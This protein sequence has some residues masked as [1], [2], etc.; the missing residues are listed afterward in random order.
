[1][2]KIYLK[3][4]TVCLFCFVL[5]SS[6]AS[7]SGVSN[8]QPDD[9]FLADLDEFYL[10]DLNILS[11]YNKKKPSA[12][13]I[14]FYCNPRTNNVK[15]RFKIGMDYIGL[16]IPYSERVKIGN[17]FD[18]YTEAIKNPKLENIKISKKTAFQ[19]GEIGIGWGV[20]GISN[21]VDTTYLASYQF[22]ENNK[23]YFALKF[24]STREI[25]E[26][27]QGNPSPVFTLYL[28]PAQ[29]RKV[30]DL[31]SQDVLVDIVNSKISSAYEYDDITDENTDVPFVFDDDE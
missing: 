9:N 20:I 26:N 11:S 18:E 7:K 12:T 28:S 2:K 4:V 29:I 13:E 10:G 24:E 3:I 6:C 1:M 25:K 19:T 30:R 8:R 14:A 5:F 31:C 23:P 17:S 27:V 16:T 15:L 22:I 21:E